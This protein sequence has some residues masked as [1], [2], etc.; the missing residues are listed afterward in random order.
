[1][2]T[3]ILYIA[4]KRYVELWNQ[5]YI[6]SEK[7]LLNK[8]NKHYFV[9][10]DNSECFQKQENITIVPIQDNSRHN[11]NLNRFSFFV[12]IEDALNLYDYCM[13]FNGNTE[14]LGEVD[15]IL[16]Y[17]DNNCLLCTKINIP[18]A[19]YARIVL[20]K[21]YIKGIDRRFYCRGGII[22]GRTKEFLEVCRCCLSMINKDKQNLFLINVVT[23]EDYYTKAIQGKN[24]L[25]VPL[26][27]FNGVSNISL[28]SKYE[29]FGLEYFNSLK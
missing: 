19:H 9:F 28:R 7:Y 24:P 16:P 17:G 22:G 21:A 10:S 2:D 23:D 8:H 13:F 1:M 25:T 20:S 3:A 14:F 29:V 5:F 15:N 12:G 11:V 27:G 4:T 18:D 26:N 6:S